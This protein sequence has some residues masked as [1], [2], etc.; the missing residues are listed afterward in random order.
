[1]TISD[2][3]LLKRKSTKYGLEVFGPLENY[4]KWLNRENFA[5]N[6]EKPIDWLST[7]K[8]EDYVESILVGLIYGDNA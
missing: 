8:G 3:D 5:F 4:K 1:M 6:W 2:E 7:K